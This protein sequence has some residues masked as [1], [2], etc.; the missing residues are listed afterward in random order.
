MRS[1][2]TALAAVLLS[3][4]ALSVSGCGLKGD[5]YLPGDEAT[6]PAPEPNEDEREESTTG[7]S[8]A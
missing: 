6:A 3:L 2:L 8:E 7:D 4:A 1:S 5:L